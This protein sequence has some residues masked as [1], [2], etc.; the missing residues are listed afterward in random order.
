[1]SA[2]QLVMPFPLFN[3]TSGNPL[4]DGSIYVGTAGLNPEVSPINVYWDAALT[5][6]A[7][8]P[9]KTMNGFIFRSGSP[10]QVYVNVTNYSLTVR[11]AAGALMYN[12]ANVDAIGGV[13]QAI[14]A[15]IHAAP[16]KSDP[17][18][19]DELGIW[20]VVSGAL[21]KITFTFLQTGAGAVLL[22]L[23][24]AIGLSIWAEHYGADPLA[25]AAINDAAIA[26]AIAEAV[27]R[28]GGVVN[29]GPGDFLTS[30]PTVLPSKVFLLGRGANA[31][32]IKLADGSDCNILESVDFAV[33]TGTNKWLVS[34]GVPYG[35]GFDCLTF[36][37][38]RANQVTAG[39]VAIYGKGY[40]IGYD[41]KIVNTKGIGFYSECAFK[42]GQN[43]E[44]DMPEGNIGKLEVY[45]SGR[46]GVVYRGPHDQPIHDIMVSQAGQDGIYDGVAF[47]AQTNIYQG[48]TY[49]TGQ[50]HAY[51]CTGR[52]ISVRCF[53][54]GANILTGENND[55]DG[56]VFEA[57]GETAGMIGSLFSNVTFAEAYGNDNNDTGLYWGIRCSGTSNTIASC[58]VSSAGQAAG[59]VSIAGSLNTL[60]GGT[61]TGVNAVA[62]GIGLKVAGNYHRIKAIVENFDSGAAVGFN[63]A[64][65]AYGNF[66]ITMFGCAVTGWLNSGASTYDHFSVTSFAAAGTPF[67]QTGTFGAQNI[68]SV[69]LNHGAAKLS[70]FDGTNS[71]ILAATTSTTLTHNGFITPKASNI[72]I[73]QTGD[74]GA[75]RMWV[76]NI[77]ATQFDVIT[78]VAPGA[79]LPFSWE[80]AI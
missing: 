25:A 63:S 2:L 10:A 30:V 22:T 39:G 27:A 20:D 46:E 1:M 38:N 61:I 24:R 54:P 15:A 57:A 69:T 67:S 68:Y 66:D 56:I 65:T 29:I 6:P 35:F 55:R 26:A 74:W 73:T 77:T 71:S 53:L 23:R 75:N 72:R 44:Q 62:D 58:R 45:M 31:T 21:R 59:G 13:Q 64:G 41:V 9:L 40:N 51:A 60:G 14:A 4:S 7:A 34:E 50:V 18:V 52:G 48:A 43:V 49:I 33:L 42:G 17:G 16:L 12:N 19:A 78:N 47:E 76:G 36:D 8:Q 3:D 80:L 79:G 11:N 28:G 37:G 32:R 70:H 5:Q